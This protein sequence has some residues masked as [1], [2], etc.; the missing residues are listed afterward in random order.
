MAD[1]AAYGPWTFV[2]VSAAVFIIFAFGF[3]PP[4]DAP[5]PV[6]AGFLP[7]SSSSGSLGSCTSFGPFCTRPQKSLR[8]GDAPVV[9]SVRS[10]RVL[11]HGPW[12]GHVEAS[13]RAGGSLRLLPVPPSGDV[14]RRA[15]VARS[16]RFGGGRLLAE[17]PR[18][19]HVHRRLPDLRRLVPSP[20]A[21]TSRDSAIAGGAPQEPPD[22][23]C[24]AR[25]PCTRPGL[26]LLTAGRAHP[27]AKASAPARA[28]GVVSARRRTL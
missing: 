3:N 26:T 27:G 7:A 22:P 19:R 5:N 4:Q 21:A 1:A 15:S 24:R 28:G 6:V 13:P 23:G 17:T 20:A 25:R 16:A 2:V 11:Q 18:L 12:R 10:L 8:S 14:G 9:S